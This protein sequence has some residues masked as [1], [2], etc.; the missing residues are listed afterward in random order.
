MSVW[1][2]WILLS[3]SS[4]PQRTWDALSV[5]RGRV[6]PGSVRVRPIRAQTRGLWAEQLL[7][8]YPV[9]AAA[10]FCSNSEVRQWELY[11]GALTCHSPNE[12]IKR[13]QRPC[14]SCQAHSSSVRFSPTASLLEAECVFFLHFGRLKL[15][16]RGEQGV[17]KEREDFFFCLFFF[18]LEPVRCRCRRSTTAAMYSE[19]T[20]VHV[21]WQRGESD[22][23]ATPH[24]P[25]RWISMERVS[26]CL[27]WSYLRPRQH[28]ECW[29][30]RPG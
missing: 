17:W 16:K 7:P 29:I 22:A 12:F 5:W 30:H 25:P 4:C 1:W 8:L 15:F 26:C 9:P 14:R 24:P 18:F 23:Y 11:R 21:V 27:L 13:W 20:S 6:T 3:S 2:F 10:R 19:E 28:R